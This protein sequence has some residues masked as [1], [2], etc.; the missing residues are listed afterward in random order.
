V[1]RAPLVSAPAVVALLVA[2]L[3]FY[4]LLIGSRGVSLLS[5]PRWTVKGLGVGVLLLPIVGIVLVGAE[6]RFGRAAARLGEQL[7][8][9]HD[10]QLDK[11]PPPTRLP[12]DEADELFA[13]RK[14]DVEADPDDWR[15]WYRLGEAY[16]L[17]GDTRRGRA[18]V[19]RAIA[20]EAAHRQR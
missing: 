1:K 2:V 6:L 19:R 16:G 14:A 11:A 10:S 7:D 4:F 12:R 15:A 9:Q 3:A 17:A 20:L 13:R 18:A 8:G 5:D